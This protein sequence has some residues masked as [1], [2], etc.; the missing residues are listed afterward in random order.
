MMTSLFIGR[1]QPLHNAHLKD[2]KDILKKS[3]KIIIAIGS[4]NK[5]NT[6]DNPFSYKERKEMI[7]SVLKANKL[8]NFRIYPVPDIK[9]DKQWVRYIK[10]NLPKYDVVYSGN[11][12]T[13]KCFS[14][15]DLK[16]RKIRLVKGISSTII[17]KKMV[18]GKKWEHLVPQQIASFIKSNACAAM[19]P[20]K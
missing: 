1:F 9:G 19:T 18:R 14:E 12:W 11:P 16:T 2:I 13:L 6:K 8:K 5:K 20:K 7:T 10:K 3:D 17:R 4:S 15:H